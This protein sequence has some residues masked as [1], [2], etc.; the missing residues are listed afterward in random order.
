MS[1]YLA[2]ADVT[3]E[4]RDAAA[5]GVPATNGL[6]PNVPNPFNASTRIAYRLATT[7]PVRLEIYNMLGQPVRTLVDESQ[8]AG[9][10]TAHWNARDQWGSVVAVGVYFTHLHF[11]GGVET[12]RL[13]YLK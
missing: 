3:T 8:T 2:P 5:Q 9:F 7:G 4:V 13:L 10:Y 11:P 6:E 12:R 1:P